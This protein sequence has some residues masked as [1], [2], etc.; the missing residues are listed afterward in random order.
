MSKIDNT[1]QGRLD[2]YI[3]KCYCG[4]DSYLEVMQNPDDG[5]FYISITQHPTRLLERLKMAWKALRGIEFT[6]SNEVILL[7]KD[8][9]KLIV[10]LTKPNRKEEK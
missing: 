3:F 7:E 4:E 1:T 6:S 8:A 2:S 10:A 5:E 9:N